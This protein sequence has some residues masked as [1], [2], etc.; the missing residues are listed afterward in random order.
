MHG[1]F[2]REVFNIM[3]KAKK[4]DQKPANPC[5]DC[6]GTGEAEDE[7]CERCGGMGV[8]VILEGTEEK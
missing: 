6:N 3:P 1:S 5:P 8:E 2:L 7:K 4:S